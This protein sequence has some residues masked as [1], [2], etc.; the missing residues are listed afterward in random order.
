[1]APMKVIRRVVLSLSDEDIILLPAD[2]Q[3]L[4]LAAPLIAGSRLPILWYMTKTTTTKITQVRTRI[5]P[6]AIPT[7]LRGW[8]YLGSVL[9]S[10]ADLP[11][12]DSWL[13]YFT[14]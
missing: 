2:W 10:D 3:F 13:H 7:D 9:L 14:R 6:E 1:M 4:H 12:A 11:A 5:V 8:D